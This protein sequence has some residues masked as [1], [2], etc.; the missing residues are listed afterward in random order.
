MLTLEGGIEGD[1]IIFWRYLLMGISR[2]NIKNYKSIKNVTFYLK[3][4]KTLHFLLHYP[5]NG[6]L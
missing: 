1:K 4:E 2:V 3:I 5:K 6:K